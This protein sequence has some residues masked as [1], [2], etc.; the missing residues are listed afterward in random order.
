MRVIGL[1]E[2][3]ADDVAEVAKLAGIVCGPERL[4]GEYRR[5]RSLIGAGSCL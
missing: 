5:R 1:I 2:G 4:S 3:V